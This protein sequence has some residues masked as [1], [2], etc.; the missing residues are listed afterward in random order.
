ME[1]STVPSELT[2]ALARP[3]SPN[4]PNRS[5]KSF[6]IFMLENPARRR[7]RADFDGFVGEKTGLAG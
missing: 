5:L 6:I 4:K 1:L 7:R 3:K 2:K